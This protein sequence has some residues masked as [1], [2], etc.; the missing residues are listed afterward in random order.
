VAFYF[1]M[2]FC[3]LKLQNQKS[4]CLLNPLLFAEVAV[5][6]SAVNPTERT[7]PDMVSTWLSFVKICDY[8]K[9]V[10]LKFYKTVWYNDSNK[11][12]RINHADFVDTGR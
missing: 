4:L 8:Y 2:S 12:R 10:F 6:Q 11:A 3:Y 9:K 5:L 1:S 7:P